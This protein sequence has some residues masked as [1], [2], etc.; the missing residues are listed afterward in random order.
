MFGQL[1]DCRTV[2]PWSTSS[3]LSPYLFFKSYHPVPRRDSILRHINHNLLGGRRR[4]Y[5]STAPPWRLM[6]FLR[7]GLR[8]YFQNHLF[9][10]TAVDNDEDIFHKFLVG[11]IEFLWKQGCQMAYF[12]TKNPDLGKIWRALE[13]KM[14][15][16]FMVIW[17]ILWPFGNLVVIWYIFPRLVYCVKKKLAT[18]FEKMTLRSNCEIP[19]G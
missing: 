7:N 8:N 2:L 4:R 6:R 15:E 18:L 9:S 11:E 10:E 16:C 14:L 17:Y 5:H 19:H 1:S 13:W 3:S 12:Q